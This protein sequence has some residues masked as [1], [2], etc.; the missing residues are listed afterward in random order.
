MSATTVRLVLRTSVG[1]AAGFG[2]DEL[3]RALEARGYSVMAQVGEIKVVLAYQ[4]DQAAPPDPS[5][6]PLGYDESYALTWQAP[7]TLALTGSDDR[8]L[9]YGVGAAA[10]LR[11]FRRLGITA[12]VPALGYLP[13]LLFIFTLQTPPPLLS[14]GCF[15]L[16][17]VHHDRP[18]AV[19]APPVHRRR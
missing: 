2:M 7:D 4:D 15:S 10:G 5:L 14:R 13:A 9:M 19:E 12:N 3:V 17:L 8:G 6:K 11:Q 16:D 1:P 18:A